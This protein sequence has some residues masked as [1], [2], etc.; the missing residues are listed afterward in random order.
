M[1][2]K[3]LKPKSKIL[4][5]DADTICYRAAKILQEDYIEV[6]YKDTNRK[7]KFKNITEFKGRK[8]TKIEGWLGDLNKNKE[9]PFLLQDFNIENKSEVIHPDTIAHKAIKQRI[10]DLS[11]LH[12]VKDIRICLGG[13]NNFRDL[14]FSGYK[15]GRPPKPLRFL[16][17]KKWMIDY[18]G[19][20]IKLSNNCESDD[21]VSAMGWFGWKV[22]QKTGENPIVMCHIDKDGDQVPGLHYNYD[23]NKLYEVSEFDA[24]KSL[25]IQCIIGDNCDSIESV[26]EANKCVQDRYAIGIG[27]IGPVKARKILEGCITIQD[28][29]REVEELYFC[30]YKEDY[31]EPLRMTYRLVKLLEELDQYELD[32]PWQL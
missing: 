5:I 6:E 28:L 17:V 31:K 13:S 32:F 9:K 18:Y 11:S 19:N 2:L 21:D 29:Y 14:I 30:Y 3:E 26:P 24:H 7:K 4:T 23:K 1:S 10:E 8:R 16:D 27:G 20:K 25:A 15:K 12:W 22:Q